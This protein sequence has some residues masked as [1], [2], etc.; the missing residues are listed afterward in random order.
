MASFILL[1]A[2]DC[3]EVRN[4][5]LVWLTRNISPNHIFLSSNKSITLT[6]RLPIKYQFLLVFR[7]TMIMFLLHIPMVAAVQLDP[8]QNILWNQP[9]ITHED[10]MFDK[11]GEYF[12]TM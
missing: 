3:L 10:F 5:G 6:K 11:V 1:E 9:L 4:P 2:G 7:K 8:S 12:L